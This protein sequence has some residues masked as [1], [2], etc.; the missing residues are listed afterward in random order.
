MIL[1]KLK[2]NISFLSLVLLPLTL[3]SLYFGL[4]ASDR[5]VSEAKLTIRQASSGGGGTGV[6]AIDALIGTSSGSREDSLHLREYILSLD[7]LK[8]LDESIGLR[9][10]YEK[11]GDFFSTLSKKA[12]Q[13]EL[14][15]YY[16]KHL[17]VVFDDV[18]GILT[19]RT[20]GFDPTYALRMNEAILTQAEIFINE[21][22]HKVAKEQL[23]FINTELELAQDEL[24]TAK[25]AQLNFQNRNKMLD[26]IDQARSM[27]AIVMQL[28][29]EKTKLEAELKQLRSYLSDS[30]PQLLALRSQIDAV[31]RQINEERAKLSGSS[32]SRLNDKA[33]QYALLEFQSQFALDK[34]KAAL[35]AY[36]KMRLEATKK[37]KHL[38]TI[39]NP[40]VQEDAEYPHRL[41][42]IATTAFVL[43][44]GFGLFRL[45]YATIQDHRE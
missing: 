17:E 19:I 38:V 21:K 13:E 22:S 2:Q 11:D 3:T 23:A 8:Y 35:G 9:A 14:L 30:A 36:E 24:T 33:A 26:P 25:E 45:L 1:D 41:Y 4:M 7:M 28:E 27:S 43:L 15:E 29:G 39:S 16:R 44:V 12:S 40:Y 37:L 6:M 34:Y 32:S 10:S 31:A 42:V 18:T 5:Y 20:Q